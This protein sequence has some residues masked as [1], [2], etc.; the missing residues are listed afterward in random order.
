[1]IEERPIGVG[2]NR[3]LGSPT[4][5]SAAN[6]SGKPGR[7]AFAQVLR[8]RLEAHRILLEGREESG[9]IPEDGGEDGA[10]M[11]MEGKT[12]GVA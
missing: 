2:L 7:P 8:E 9:E 11:L 10:W 1:L 5:R 12:K 3:N 4:T 6:G